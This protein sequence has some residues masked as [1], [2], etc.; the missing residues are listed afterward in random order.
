MIRQLSILFLTAPLLAGQE[1]EAAVKKSPISLLPNG[2]VLQ[3]VLLPRYDDERRLVGDLKA[4][5]MTLI[6]GTRIQGQDVLIRFYNPDRTLSGRVELTRALFDQE[7]SSLYAKQD[8]KLIR[9]QLTATGGGLVY[10]FETGQGFLLGPVSTRLSPPPVPTSMNVNPLT[11][12]AAALIAFAPAT[13]TAAPPAFVSPE[14]LA[15]I[16]EEAQSAKPKIDAANQSASAELSADRKA[17]AAASE[18]ATA[19]MRK[20]NINTIA[21]EGE[22]EE[23]KPLEVDP[24]PRGYDHH[25]RWRN[26]LRCR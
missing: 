4:D 19:F 23:A 22:P 24:G 11:F 17:A 7:K 12:P 2:S 21:A 15:E 25:V 8:V 5:V 16:K 13:L 10:S 6:D 18:S 1:P 3:G 20:N 9:D 26:V 14:E